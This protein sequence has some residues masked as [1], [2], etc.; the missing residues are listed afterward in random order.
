[1]WNLHIRT[2]G[3]PFVEGLWESVAAAAVALQVSL[4]EATFFSTLTR[5]LSSI[6]DETNK[7][8]LYLDS[9]RQIARSLIHSDPAIQEDILMHPDLGRANLIAAYLRVCSGGSLILTHGGRLGLVPSKTTE[10][11]DKCCIFLGAPAPFI[12]A[13]ATE[14]HYKLV[15]EVYIHGVMNGELLKQ[16]CDSGNFECANI[17]LG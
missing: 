1:M 3:E 12:L 15:R 11:G 5:G 10:V 6:Q 14:G 16:R 13:P 4:D 8:K 9:Y 2:T 17:L 7:T